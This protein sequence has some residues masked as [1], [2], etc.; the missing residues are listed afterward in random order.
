M[1]LPALGCVTSDKSL[2]VSETIS[3]FREE[4]RVRAMAR[5]SREGGFAHTWHLCWAAEDAWEPEPGLGSGGWG[6]GGEWGE[7][8]EGE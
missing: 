4:V 2:R 8:G 3:L 1:A 7:R 6:K 5:C